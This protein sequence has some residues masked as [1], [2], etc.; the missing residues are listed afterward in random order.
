MYRGHIH[1]S[2]NLECNICNFVN[3]ARFLT[4]VIFWEYNS[5]PASYKYFSLCKNNLS[6]FKCV[7]SNELIKSWNNFKV[8][9]GNGYNIW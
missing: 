6:S 7:V 2:Y 3:L 4:D 1:V 8:C 5:V 9:M